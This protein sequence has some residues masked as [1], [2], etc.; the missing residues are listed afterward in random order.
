[1]IFSARIDL[2]SSTAPLCFLY[3][4]TLS[5]SLLFL[6]AFVLRLCL[7]RNFFFL[8]ISVLVYYLVLLKKFYVLSRV[9]I[10]YFCGKENYTSSKSFQVLKFLKF[11]PS[12][13]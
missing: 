12:L 7:K 3:A 8:L 5:F 13:N 10:V 6:S 2:P 11:I 4:I 1:M 9:F